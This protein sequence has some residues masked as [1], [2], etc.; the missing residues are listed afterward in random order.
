MHIN[1]TKSRDRDSGPVMVFVFGQNIAI[2]IYSKQRQIRSIS[3]RSGGFW[4]RPKPD[5]QN[6]RVRYPP[7]RRN[8]GNAHLNPPLSRNS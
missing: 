6:L 2:E 8:R 4:P 7:R 5:W 3:K 1:E